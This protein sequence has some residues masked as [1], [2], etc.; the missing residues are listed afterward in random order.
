MCDGIVRLRPD[1]PAVGAVTSRPTSF[2]ILHDAAHPS[3]VILPVL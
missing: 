3:Q 2:E 1:S